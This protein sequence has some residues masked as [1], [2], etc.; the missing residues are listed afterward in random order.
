MVFV[1][2]FMSWFIKFI[3]NGK[4]MLMISFKSEW[5]CVEV[6]EYG[7]DWSVVEKCRV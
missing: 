4:F 5:L 7:C 6:G 1:K 3:E 2:D